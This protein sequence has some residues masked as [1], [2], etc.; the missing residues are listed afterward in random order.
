MRPEQLPKNIEL[1]DS[2]IRVLE[3]SKLPM[4]SKDID[5]AVAEELELLQSQ[6]EVMRTPSRS[7]YKY[8][9]AWA[10]TKLKSQ[11]LIVK[12]EGGEWK[13]RS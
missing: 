6:L 1:L 2:I 3:S 12:L 10:R 13:I 7:E 4:S 9:M 5:L 8:R 11:G